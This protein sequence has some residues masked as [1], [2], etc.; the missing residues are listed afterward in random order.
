MIE[1]SRHVLHLDPASFTC[2]TH[3]HDLTPQVVESL[4][5]QGPPVAFGNKKRL[6]AVPV[7]CPGGPAPDGAHPQ[8]CRGRYWR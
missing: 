2:P 8:V 7:S 5:E 6:F 1:R 3:G 4:E